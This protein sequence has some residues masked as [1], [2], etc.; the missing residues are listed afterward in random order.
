[1]KNSQLPEAEQKPK[2]NLKDIKE[3]TQARDMPIYII[4]D[5]KYWADRTS[6]DIL[7][8]H[9]DCEDCGEEFEKQFT[10][11][12]RCSNCQRKKENEDFDKMEL[13]E[14]DG[15]SML[16]DYNSDDKYFNDL[17]D[18]IEYCADN[19]I[20]PE[21]IKLV[22]CYQTSFPKIDIYEHVQDEVHEDWD[23]S[24]KLVE[25]VAALNDYLKTAPTNTW[26]PGNKRVQLT[27]NK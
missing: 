12:K 7:A 26:M 9:R 5:K 6:I 11:E 4:G 19:E 18:I 14:W 21:S 10:H 25:L 2:V 16:F 24:A 20:E 8:T 3:A 27:F 17:D 13:V 15:T 23:P 1:M 22:L